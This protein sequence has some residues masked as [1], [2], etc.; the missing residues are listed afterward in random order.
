MRQLMQSSSLDTFLKLAS[1]PEITLQDLLILLIK[2]AVELSGSQIAI[3]IIDPATWMFEDTR[4]RALEQRI[5]INAL[6]KAWNAPR[7]WTEPSRR[8]ANSW[9]AKVAAG[10]EPYLLRHS[11]WNDVSS[12]KS[13]GVDPVV[14]SPSTLWVPLSDDRECLGW[15]GLGAARGNAFGSALIN[16]IESLISA[17]LLVV[18]RI[19]LRDHA[20]RI[21]L[22]INLVGSSKR[23]LRLEQ[24]IKQVASQ[25]RGPVLIRGERGSGKELVA[26]A[27]H[28]FSKRRDKS[29]VPVLAPALSDGLQVDEL[30]GH[31]RNSFT[32]ATTSRRGKFLAAN[33]GTLFLDEVGD[34]SVPLQLALLRAIERGEIQPIGRDLPIKVDV[35]VIAATNKDLHELIARG[36]FRADLYDRLNVIELEVPPLRERIE[37]ITLLASHFL[38]KQCPDMNRRDSIKKDQV[39]AQ[40]D[41]GQGVG[42]AA[43]AFYQD[44]IGYDWPGNVR[45][46]ENMIIRLTTLSPNQILD[47][48]HALEHLPEA[49]RRDRKDRALTA[50]DLTLD[51]VVRTHIEH[52]L[53]LTDRNKTN[54]AKTLGIARTTLQGKMKKLGMDKM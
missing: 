11:E 19:L 6:Q 23:F 37:D 15:L 46:L 50:E 31:E 51:G 10:Q 16:S 39:C 35:R 27:L 4:R 33:G 38:L 13:H 14:N 47:T 21:G 43:Q 30:F 40:C 34:I 24:E 42:C 49:A 22:D 53:Q 7:G 48:I 25:S 20:K 17:A 54:A 29:F 5:S 1:R 52:I 3:A 12:S 18:G 2:R 36:S 9:L 45:E 32:G 44:L 41:A 26:Y 8:K 28:Y